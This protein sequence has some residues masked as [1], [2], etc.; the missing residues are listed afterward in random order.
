MLETDK[1]NNLE[2]SRAV[3]QRRCDSG[4]PANDSR[5]EALAYLRRKTHWGAAYA[6]GAFDAYLVHW[7][8]NG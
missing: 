2:A 5:A 3:Y 8:A 4:I 7:R 1:L 6:A